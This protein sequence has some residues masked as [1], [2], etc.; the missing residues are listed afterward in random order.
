MKLYGFPGTRASRVRWMLEEIGAPYEWV[1][2]EIMKGEH[3]ETPHLKRHAHGRLPA[4]E[5]GDLKM[6][7]SGAMVMYLCDKFAGKGFAPPI[8]SPARGSYYQWIV[9]ASAMLD[10]P[11]IE[12]YF[13][14]ALFPPERRKPEVVEKHRPTVKT[15]LDLL[16]DNLANKSYLL[17]DTFSG[18]DVAVGYAIALGAQANLLGDHPHVAAWFGRI[19][20]RPAFGKAFAR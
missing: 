5:D 8:D 11:F 20:A 2:V 10:E 9:Y 15:A 19:S 6:I 17:G 13:H 3:K 7:E 4:F 18:A 14:A 12:T 16:N 1:N